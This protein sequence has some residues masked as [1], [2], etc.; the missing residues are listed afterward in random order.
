MDD[1][2]GRF[3]GEGMLP[4]GM[5]RWLGDSWT[6]VGGYREWIEVCSLWDV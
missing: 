4:G 1:G 5:E 3:G 6:R 2:K